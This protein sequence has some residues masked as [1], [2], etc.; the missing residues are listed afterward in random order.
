MDCSKGD[1][2]W[3]RAPVRACRTHNPNRFPLPRNELPAKA[4]IQETTR[5]GHAASTPTACLVA[6]LPRF[7]RFNR[8]RTLFDLGPPATGLGTRNERNREVPRATADR[9]L[10]GRIGVSENRSTDMKHRA[11][12]CV[13]RC[14]SDPEGAVEISGSTRGGLPRSLGTMR[15]TGTMS[16][17]HM[18]IRF[19]HDRRSS[20]PVYLMFRAASERMM[21]YI[22]EIHSSPKWMRAIV[23]IC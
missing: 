12:G 16:G 14:E 22:D 21:M 17:P 6:P 23:C 15:G 5:G 20:A 1:I 10:R 13:G 8:V 7:N 11:C 3:E 2:D 9:W 18:F 4:G 19:S